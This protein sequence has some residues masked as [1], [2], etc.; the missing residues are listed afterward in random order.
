MTQTK[1]R[2]K[3]FSWR[4]K[5]VTFSGITGENQNPEYGVVLFYIMEP[6]YVQGKDL[7]SRWNLFATIIVLDLDVL[8][9]R[10]GLLVAL[11]VAAAPGGVS[12]ARAA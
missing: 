5:Q 10:L 12:P 9:S 6:E 4:R 11:N 7:P 8:S 3:F 1:E 2:K